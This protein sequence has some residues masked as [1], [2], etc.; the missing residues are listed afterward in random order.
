MQI[1]SYGPCWA[2][3]QEGVGQ[4]DVGGAYRRMIARHLPQV[5]GGGIAGA[6]LRQQHAVVAMRG[7]VRRRR[8][9][10]ALERLGG[11]LRMAGAQ[12]HARDVGE[13]VG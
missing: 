13:D 12:V 4:V 10:G 7:G 9:Q 6:G 5:A 1:G 11:G 8:A 3:M 2:G